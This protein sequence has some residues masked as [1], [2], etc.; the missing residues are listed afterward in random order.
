[1]A[2][3]GDTLC[4]AHIG[5]QKEKKNLREICEYLSTNR[6]DRTQFWRRVGDVLVGNME[7]LGQRMKGEAGQRSQKGSHITG[8][9]SIIR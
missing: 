9:H 6:I 2:A 8:S 4:S 7:A 1:M 3:D 5:P